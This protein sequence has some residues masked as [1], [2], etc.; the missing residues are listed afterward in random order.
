[1][2]LLEYRPSQPYLNTTDPHLFEVAEYLAVRAGASAVVVADSGVVA[3]CAG[4]VHTKLTRTRSCRGHLAAPAG[5]GAH[6]P[7]RKLPPYALGLH[8]VPQTLGAK[9]HLLNKP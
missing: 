7:A 1:M 6:P 5:V 4:A 2:A 9:N 3:G 8:T